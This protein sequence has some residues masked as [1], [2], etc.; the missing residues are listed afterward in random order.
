M[1]LLMGK[2]Q[3]FTQCL[4]TYQQII[5]KNCREKGEKYTDALI[6]VNLKEVQSCD[7]ERLEQS[8]LTSFVQAGNI[9]SSQH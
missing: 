3:Q 8:L 9:N 4:F 5:K 6:T 1:A 2:K 7:S